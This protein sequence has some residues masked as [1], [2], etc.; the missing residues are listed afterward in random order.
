LRSLARTDPQ[1]AIAFDTSPAPGQSN[2]DFIS[3][4]TALD[5]LIAINQHAFD[6]AIAAGEDALGGWTSGISYGLCALLAMAVLLGVR[7]RLAEYR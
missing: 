1:Q 5:A 3:Y 7:P 6:T 2:G 4:N